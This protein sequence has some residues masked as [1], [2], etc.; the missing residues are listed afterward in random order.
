MWKGKAVDRGRQ[1]RTSILGLMDM[2]KKKQPKTGQD[3]S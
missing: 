2:V 1:A 3:E